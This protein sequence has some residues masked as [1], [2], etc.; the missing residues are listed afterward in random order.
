MFRI[1]VVHD[2]A[3][4]PG[5]DQLVARKGAQRAER[6]RPD[7]VRQVPGRGVGRQHLVELVLGD[8]DE[9]DLDPALLGER[10]DDLLRGGHPLGQ[11]LDDPDLDAV[12]VAATPPLVVPAAGG[13]RG[14]DDCRK[15]GGNAGVAS[16]GDGHE[17]SVMNGTFA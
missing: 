14:D 7:H 13:E 12:I 2:V 3:D 6:Q 17:A 1:E 16:A 5:V 11:V 10:V 4:S 9:L 15:N 8:R